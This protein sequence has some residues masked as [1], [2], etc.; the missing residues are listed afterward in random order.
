MIREKRE[1][2]GIS[3]ISGRVDG[4]SLVN[5]QTSQ[6]Q[7]QTVSTDTQTEN[8]DSPSAGTE[9]SYDT[10]ETDSD[11]EVSTEDS[12]SLIVVKFCFFFLPFFS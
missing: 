12:S 2:N 6:S 10:I 9:E 8:T 11:D 7:D 4:R 5:P 1:L 3:I